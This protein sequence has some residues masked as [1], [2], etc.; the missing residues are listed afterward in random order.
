VKERAEL[1]RDY[2]PIILTA[3][4]EDRKWRSRRGLSTLLLVAE[5]SVRLHDVM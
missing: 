2:W 4:L 1:P 3:L 5:Y